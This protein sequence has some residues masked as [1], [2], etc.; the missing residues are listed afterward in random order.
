M[1]AELNLHIRPFRPDDLPTL[2]RI[3]AD[4]FDGVSIDQAI[5]R[6]FGQINGHDWKWR[7]RRHV[8][9]DVRRDAE[10]I[11]VAEVDGRIVGC[12]STWQDHEAGIGHI[13]NIAFVP[14]FRGRGLGRKLITLAMERF[15]NSGLTHAKIETLVQNDVGN[16]LYQSLG[17]REVARQTHFLA[18]LDPA[19]NAP[20]PTDRRQSPPA[21]GH[22]HSNNDP[23]S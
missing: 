14:E 23:S 1:P 10:G 8:D 13:P 20:S 12:I 22:E 9:E 21:P 6:V 11:F 15:R 17:F 2:R 5:E 3:V 18:E 7:K 19:D 4:A 16:H